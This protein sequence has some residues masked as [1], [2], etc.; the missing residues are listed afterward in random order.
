MPNQSNLPIG[1]EEKQHKN[2]DV[3]VSSLGATPN[4]SKANAQPDSSTAQGKRDN[5]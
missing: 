5:E 4:L 2:Y 1:Q 3:D